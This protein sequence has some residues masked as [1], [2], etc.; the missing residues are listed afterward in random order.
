MTELYRGDPAAN[1][2]VSLEMLAE[3]DATIEQLR[4]EVTA[5]TDGLRTIRDSYGQ[6]CTDF[7]TCDHISCRS[8]Y[9]AWQ[10]AYTVLKTLEMIA[11]TPAPTPSEEEKRVI[12]MWKVLEHTQK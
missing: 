11:V 8:S 3:R 7:E 12:P 4:G 10:V 6:V 2:R 9:S 1:N 5:L